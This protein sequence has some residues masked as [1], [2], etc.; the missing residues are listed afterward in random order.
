MFFNPFPSA[1]GL[2]IGDLSI[3]L[4]QLRNVS[5]RH[6]EAAYEIAT[7]RTVS[8]PPGL[9]V[10]GELQQPEKVR[11]YIQHLLKGTGDERPIKSP[12]VVTSLPETQSFIK[13]ITLNKPAE[14]IIE[15][16]VLSSAEKHIPFSLDKYFLDW[17][18]I[19]SL[20]KDETPV[21]IG[22]APKDIC[23]SYTYL[24]GTLQLCVVALEIEALAI[25]RSM[26]TAKKEYDNEARAILDLGAVRSSLI[27]YDKD[28]LQFNITLPYS[29]E[30]V[31]TLLAQKLHISHEDAEKKKKEVG[32]E[33]QERNNA[34]WTIVAGSVDDLA[35]DIK[36]AIEFYYSHF[37]GANKITHITMC[38]G[39]SEMKKLDSLLSLKLGIE[40]KPGNPWKNLSEHAADS[41][42]K[43]NG[44]EFCT[45]IGLALRAAENPFFPSS[46]L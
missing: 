8:L 19:D 28:V 46:M 30:L 33:F 23:N 14:E 29:G 43:K 3:K 15:D 5:L 17:Q 6:R 38:G 22:A 36:K 34:V 41:I 40:A 13:L 44:L 35:R 37:P 27:I 16:D 20:A 24:M 45:A 31:T 32:V 39:G 10:N 25:A 4:V 1:F 18:I 7:M 21:L 2:D 42:P 9:I 26:I 12:W 11:K